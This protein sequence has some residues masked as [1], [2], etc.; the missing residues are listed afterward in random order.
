MP[1][2]I[3][4]DQCAR[5]RKVSLVGKRSIRILCDLLPFIP[6]FKKPYLVVLWYFLISDKMAS[7][8][9]I[10]VGSFTSQAGIVPQ[11]L[12]AIKPITVN[13]EPNA[14][15]GYIVNDWSALQSTLTKICAEVV[16]P[17]LGSTVIIGTIGCYV[18]SC[19][20][21]SKITG[22]S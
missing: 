21:T 17:N 9:V 14:F 8:V 18:H 12:C 10:D 15:K 7:T 3:L 16:K 19:R 6:E 11:Q 13:T 1:D 22:S 4:E 20:L 2:S 5:I